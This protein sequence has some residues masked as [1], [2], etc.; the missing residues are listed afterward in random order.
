MI[1]RSVLGD[2]NKHKAHVGMLVHQYYPIDVRVRRE[3]E[4]LVEAGYRVEVVCLRA[5]KEPRKNREPYKDKVNGVQVYRLPIARKRSKTFRYLYEYLGLMILGGFTLARIHFLDPFQVVHV[6]NM[7]DLLVLAGLIP[8]WM[9]AKLLLDIHDPMPEL[10]KLKT[11]I[12][13]ERW[14]VKAL[15]WEEKFSC[16]LAHYVISVNSAMYKNLRS[17]GIPSKKIFILHNFPDTKYLPVKYD[18]TRWPYHREGFILLYAGTVTEHYRLD[19][20]VRAL[21]LV[22]KDIPCIKLRILGDGNELSRILQLANNLGLFMYVEH[23]KPV[24]FDKVKDIMVDADVGITSHQGG[25]FG[26]V[27]FATKILDYLS[28]G[29]PVVSSRT[30]TILSYIPED[31]I[32]YFEPEDASD[33]AKKIIEIWNNPDLVRR[34]M[35]NA[36]KILDK[37]TWEEEKQKFTNFYQEILK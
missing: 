5:P 17:K 34:K 35:E 31:A 8:K 6:H 7:P 2:K 13:Q 37:Y 33:M 11:K 9:G 25:I 22:I 30:K 19:I 18:I 21:A 29:L 16:K 12:V 3:A 24:D 10:Y 15:K 14:I 23:L 27:Y 28:Q 20:A 1:W 4:A 26:D 32:F 36:K